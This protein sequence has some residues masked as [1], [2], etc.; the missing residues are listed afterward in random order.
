LDE[1][2]QRPHWGH[3]AP[4]HAVDILRQAGCSRLVLFH[5][6]QFRTDAQLDA[7]LEASRRDAPDLDMVAAMEHME[8]DV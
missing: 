7:V 5:H 3:S 8:I 1:Y 4:E 2:G 6:A